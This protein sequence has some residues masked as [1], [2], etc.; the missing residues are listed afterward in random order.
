L[1][2]A[3]SDRPAAETEAT[4]SQ[5]AQRPAANIAIAAADGGRLAENIM[6]FGRL[7]RASGMRVGPDRARLAAEAVAATG[8]DDP[9]RLY[10]TL[11]AVFVMRRADRDI[12]N[13]AFVMFWKDPGYLEQMLSLVVPNFRPGVAED[14]KAL[15][16]RLSES[17]FQ[18][19]EGA[20]T[21]DRDLLEI[22]ARGTFSAVETFETKDFEQMSAAELAAAR[23][24]IAAMALPFD[25]IRTRRWR[26]A[27]SGAQL[28]T[29]AILREMSTKGRDHVRPQWKARVIKPPPLVL[30]VDVSGSM[31][32]YARVLLHF[33]HA[34]AADR[35]RVW[36]FLFGTR[37]TNVTRT[38]LNR[39]PD[40]AIAKV[41]RDVTDWAGGTRIGAALDTFNRDWA[42]RVL[43]QNA[44]VLLVTDGLD[45]DGGEGI[46][47]AARRLKAASR[48]LIWLN[49]LMR[50]DRYQPI[51]SGAAVL[52]AHA[53]ATA[54][55]HNLASLKAIAEAL[56]TTRRHG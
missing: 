43:G 23:Q 14:D 53:D 26:P 48:R 20:P 41:G 38:L 1:S 54:A 36:V 24:A 30:L 52:S 47:P 50:F 45:R 11:H 7:L 13:Q 56:V 46:E 34:L 33:A 21:D 25:R 51:A 49:P 19:A 55:C 2:R 15:S 9:R 35:P 39:D 40:A 18:K 28:D 31:D 10:W 42:R 32:A 29:R 12:F 4:P 6:H 3:P 44:T 5:S 27:H 37:L 16:R 17:L 8:L 22:E